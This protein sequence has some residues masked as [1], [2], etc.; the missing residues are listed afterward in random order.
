MQ[1]ATTGGIG[2]APVGVTVPEGLFTATFSFTAGQLANTGSLDATLGRTTS[3]AITVSDPTPPPV[4]QIDISGWTLRQASAT[5]SYTFPTNT[6]LTAG[7]YAVVGRNATKSAFESHWSVTLAQDV[8]YFDS[9]DAFPKINGDE[10]YSLEDAQGNTVDGTTIAMGA[11][12]GRNLQ[13]SVPVGA[14]GNSG[15]WV[16]VS[17]STSNATPGSG[18]ATPSS[19][20]GV[21]ISEFSDASGSGAFV[22]EFVEVHFDGEPE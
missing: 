1:L 14:A 6:V 7:G 19:P 11:S 13:R 9:V 20:T 3:A 2:A 17:A 22:Y 16:D 10:T 15:S 18:Q 21:Y 4:T 12:A 8:L 5:W